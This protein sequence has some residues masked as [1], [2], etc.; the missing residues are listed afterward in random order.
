MPDNINNAPYRIGE[1]FR[2]APV[3]KSITFERRKPF[4]AMS[5][6]GQGPTDVKKDLWENKANRK[7]PA[8]WNRAAKAHTSA[9]LDILR[10]EL[11]SFNELGAAPGATEPSVTSATER[12]WWGSLGNTLIQTGGVFIQK[13]QELQLIK[14]Q[15]QAQQ[16]SYAGVFPYIGMP[17]EGGIGILGWSAIAALG[18][19]TIS[20]IIMKNK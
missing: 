5:W 4:F 20:Y 3:T 2:N 1:S 14:V 17:S 10:N 9:K 7:F 8:V 11:P 6:A 12:S 15:A 16:R 19:G 18:L 13:Q